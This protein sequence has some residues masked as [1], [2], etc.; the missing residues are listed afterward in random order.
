MDLFTCICRDSQGFEKIICSLGLMWLNLYI[1]T[2]LIYTSGPRHSSSELDFALCFWL[3]LKKFICFLWKKLFFWRCWLWYSAPVLC[4]HSK[5]TNPASIFLFRYMRLDFL[6]ISSRPVSWTCRR[7]PA[8]LFPWRWFLH[9][10]ALISR[11]IYLWY[12]FC[13]LMSTEGFSF[14]RKTRCQEHHIL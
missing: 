6:C 2:L 14:N 5:Q 4:L 1:W 13:W 8:I 9:K 3:Y 7:T 12:I 10:Q 11:P